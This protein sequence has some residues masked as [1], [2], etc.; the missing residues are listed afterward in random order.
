MKAAVKNAFSRFGYEIQ[1]KHPIEAKARQIYSR[2]KD[3]TMIPE[4]LFVDNLKLV[5]DFKHARGCVV[6]CG[7]WKGGMSAGMAEVLNDR[8]FFLFDSFEGLPPAKEIDGERALAW[9][10]N[11]EG[12]YYYNNCS[13]EMDFADT[14]MRNTGVKFQ[15]VKGWFSQTLPSAEFPHPISI[16]RLDSD[17]YEST[18]DCLVNLYSKVAQGGIIIFDDYHTFDGCSRAVHDF[19]SKTS[20]PVRLHNAY[21]GVAYLRKGK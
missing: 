11:K 17:W 4:S 16:L 8:E 9:Q 21:S 2:C 12:A 6:E 5:W 19:L 14:A 7:V 10:K 1:K 3:Y 18:M 15:L 20:V 13:A